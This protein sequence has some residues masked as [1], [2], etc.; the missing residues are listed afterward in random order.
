MMENKGKKTTQWPTDNGQ[1]DNTMG[2][3]KGTKRHHNS[4]KKKDKNTAQWPNERLH[5]E[6]RVTKRKRTTRHYNDQ[7]KKWT[8]R[9][10]K[11]ML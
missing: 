4:Q 3:G 8:K 6:K 10:Y 2:K 9:K 7:R 11:E 1:K 5:N